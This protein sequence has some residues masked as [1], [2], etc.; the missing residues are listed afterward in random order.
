MS[1]GPFLPYLASAVLE[2]RQLRNETTGAY[3][4]AAAAVQL[5]D[6]L[7][8]DGTP[9]AGA[10]WPLVLAYVP[11]TNGT[12]R[13][14][15]PAALALTPGAV[16]KARLAIDLDGTTKDYRELRLPCRIRGEL[17]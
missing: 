16:Y 13:V 15:L 2:I 12:W 17:G 4:V 5:L 6:I 9:V 10:P 3:I 1:T 8:A 14:Q 7:A 11:G